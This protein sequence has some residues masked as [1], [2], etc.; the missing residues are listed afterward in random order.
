MQNSLKNKKIVVTKGGEQT[1]QSLSLLEKAG[2]EILYFP[3]LKII[4]LYNNPLMDVCLAKFSD[5]DYLIFTSVNSVESFEAYCQSVNFEPNY[6]NI[7]VA[8]VG[9]K[10]KSKC[11][12]AGIPVSITPKEYSAK[13][14]LE[15]FSK[16]DIKGKKILIP[17]S[18]IARDELKTGLE[19]AGAVIDPVPVYDVVVPD[20]QDVKDEIDLINKN[21]YD[22]FIFTSPSALNNFISLLDISSETDFFKKKIIAAIGTTTAEALRNKNLAVNII[23]DEFTLEG[24][25]QKLIDYF[26]TH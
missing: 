20:K 25:S 18:A 19:K 21:N 17:C 22:V 8:V 16:Y 10:T 24:V 26:N 1:G 12:E 7:S 3:V 11:G 23:P 4:T 14:L 2:A 13:G 6:Y 9:Q 15:A 5:Y